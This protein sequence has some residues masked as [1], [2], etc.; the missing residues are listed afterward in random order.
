MISSSIRE[1]LTET[2]VFV[3]WIKKKD[4]KASLVLQHKNTGRNNSNEVL[5]PLD[6]S[7]A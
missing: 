3:A 1:F 6:V 7:A 4:K 5:F 2:V